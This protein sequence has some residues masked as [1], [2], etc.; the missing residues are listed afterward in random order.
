MQAKYV[1]L[2]ADSGGESH[3]Q[4]LES[5]LSLVDFAPSAPCLFISPLYRA[6]Q[7]SFFGAPAGWSSDWHP[8]SDRNLFCVISG[9]WEIGASDGEVRRCSQGD[10]M[11]VEDT[12][13]KGHTSRVISGVDSLALLIALES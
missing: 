3:F 7:V 12:T 4:D 8:S 11:L 6:T 2:F 13:G 5:E 10:V 1:R 9:E